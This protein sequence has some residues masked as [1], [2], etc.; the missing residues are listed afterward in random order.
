MIALSNDCESEI[1]VNAFNP[2]AEL[3][4]NQYFN[5]DLDYINKGLENTVVVYNRWGDIV[6]KTN[7]YDN[8][9]T[10]WRGANSKG[11]VMP[12]G[13]YFYTVEVPSK[14][15]STNGWVYLNK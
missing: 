10:V 3:I 6:Y 14:D 4:E 1:P 12:E 9:G 13:T 15:F 5:I 2:N 7:N 11:V 8:K